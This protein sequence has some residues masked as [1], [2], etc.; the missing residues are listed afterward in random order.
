[1]TLGY[2]VMNNRG[3]GKYMEENQSDSSS[4]REDYNLESPLHTMPETSTGLRACFPIRYLM[5]ILSF[6]GFA[7]VYGMR[8]NLSIAIVKMVE[9]T[10]VTLPD[11]TS[12]VH[13]DFDWGTAK[14]GIILSSFFW[15]Y[16]ITQLPGGLLAGKFGGMKIYGFGI[17]STSFFTI[18]TP[19]VTHYG[20]FEWL[21]VLRILEGLGEGV[22]YP[23]QYSFWSKW[24]PKFERTKLITMSFCGSYAGTVVAMPLCGLLAEYYGWE[25]I[26]YVYGCFGLLWTILWSMLAAE[27]PENHRFI[28][29][30]EMQHIRQMRGTDDV[31]L[32]LRDIPWRHIFTSLPVYAIVAAHFSENWGFYT[33]LTE[34]PTFMKDILHFDVKSSGFLAAL[35]YLV[36][37][38]VL[39]LVGQLSDF[40]RKEKYL[41]TV[42]VRKLFNTIGYCFQLVFLL[43]TGFTDNATSAVVYLTLG[44]GLGG[45]AIASFNVNHLDI[46]PRYACILMGIS[47]TVCTIPGILSPTITGLITQGK[48]AEEWKIVFYISSAIYA[49][50]AVIYATLASG[51]LQPWGS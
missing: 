16:I 49:F 39:I 23:A 27:T 26:F 18:L 9:K 17:L 7:N 31:N 8:V 34:L 24:A 25:S 46:S 29:D 40:L 28:S 50:G 36:L 42:A 2:T 11:G 19:V 32:N 13:Q 10:N 33:M 22:T 43:L 20:G 15:G 37:T 21:L 6:F 48:T 44:V 30:L 14:Q 3:Q 1:M 41:S 5:A 45:F 51:N 47:N 35:P 38:I 12:Q 4:N